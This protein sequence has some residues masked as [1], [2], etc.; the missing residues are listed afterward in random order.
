ML[1]CSIV[2]IIILR[3]RGRRD[4]LLHEAFASC[5][6]ASRRPRYRGVIIWL[7]YKQAWN[8]C[9]ITKPIWWNTMQRSLN[10]IAIDDAV[11]LQNRNFHQICLIFV[12][13]CSNRENEYPHFMFLTI[14]NGVVGVQSCQTMPNFHHCC[15]TSPFINERASSPRMLISACL[16][17]T[18]NWDTRP[19]YSASHIV[20]NIASSIVQWLMT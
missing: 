15:I 17:L 1:V 4:A 18:E 14:N 8:N 3:C 13:K 20:E 10:G 9:F 7:S 12:S 5:N 16:F 11:L 6:S 19:W 2:K